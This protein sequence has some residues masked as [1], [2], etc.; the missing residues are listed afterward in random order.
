MRTSPVLLHI[1][2]ASLDIPSEWRSLFHLS[3]EALERELVIMTDRYTDNLFDLGE[4]AERLVF[5]VSRLLVDPERFLSDQAEP[6]ASRGMGA[7]YTKTHDGQPLKSD[8]AR[9]RLLDT[10]YTPHHEALTSWAR[11]RLREHGRCLIIDCHSFP[12]RPLPCDMNQA[13]ERP[14]VCIGTT[15]PHTSTWL[16]GCAVNAFVDLGLSVAVDEPY[17]GTIVPMEYYG[18]ESRLSSIMIEINRS[19]YM[20]ETTAERLERFQSVGDV[21]RRALIAIVD[22][23]EAN[24]YI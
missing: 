10:Y 16:E 18:K 8:S 6:M 7:I 5:P 4:R 15:S 24:D 17:K 14:D 19:L 21:L 23:W 2:H 9:Q 20:D 11:E 3:E 13:P 12:S 1:P 22:F